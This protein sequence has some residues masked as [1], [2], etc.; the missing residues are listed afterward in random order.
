MLDPKL[1]DDLTRRLSGAIP[2]AAKAMQADMEKNLRAAVQS[3]LSRLDL[4]TREEFDV[5]TKVLARSRAKIEQLE[6]QVGELEARL[7]KDKADTQG[8][9]G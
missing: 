6:K 2:P 1:L 9:T 8:T 4:V 7:L 3:A 5:Q